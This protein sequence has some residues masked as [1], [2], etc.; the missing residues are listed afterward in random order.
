MPEDYQDDIK[1]LAARGVLELERA[2]PDMFPD[3]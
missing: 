3:L 2:L 1:A